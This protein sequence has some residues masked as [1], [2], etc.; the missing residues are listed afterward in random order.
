MGEKK[1]NKKENKKEKIVSTFST[2]LKNPSEHLSGL[3]H[4]HDDPID[5]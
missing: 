4:G 3:I 2:R 1:K 5:K